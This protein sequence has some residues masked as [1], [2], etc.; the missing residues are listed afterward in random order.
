M[1]KRG[2]PFEIGRSPVSN[3]AIFESSKLY[4]TS[5]YNN[6]TSDIGINQRKFTSD[7]IT[8]VIPHTANPQPSPL[9]RA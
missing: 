2:V 8:Q 1:I 3:Q 6:N 9:A 5:P 4:Q 7:N